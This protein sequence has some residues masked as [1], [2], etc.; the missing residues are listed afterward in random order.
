MVSPWDSPGKNTGVGCHFLLQGI[1]PT[2]GSNPGL[3]RCGWIPCR[4][5]HQGSLEAHRVAFG[6]ITSGVAVI[7]GPGGRDR[8]LFL[9]SAWQIIVD[10]FQWTYRFLS[11][12]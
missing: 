7:L 9:T 11:D 10:P 1:F 4:L 5:S 12:L 8:V 2:Q 3:L 6:Y